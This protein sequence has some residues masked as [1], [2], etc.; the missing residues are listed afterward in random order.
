MDTDYKWYT[1]HTCHN[2]NV[3]IDTV[4]HSKTN[5]HK[6]RPKLLEQCGFHI[7]ETELLKNREFLYFLCRC[8]SITNTANR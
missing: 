1:V 6:M 7:L 5:Q 3:H 4:F 2:G 8:V